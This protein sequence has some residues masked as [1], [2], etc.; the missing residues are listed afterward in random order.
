M[1]QLLALALACTMS[2]AILFQPLLMG[3]PRKETRTPAAA[4]LAPEAAE[5]GTRNKM[6]L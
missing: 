1:G 3:P 4:D 5:R 6:N 2:A